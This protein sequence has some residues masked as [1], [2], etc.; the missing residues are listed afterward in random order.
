MTKWVLCGPSG[1]CRF[2]HT[3]CRPRPM[4]TEASDGAAIEAFHRISAALSC[5]RKTA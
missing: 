1:S 3:R 5:E 4:C 2:H